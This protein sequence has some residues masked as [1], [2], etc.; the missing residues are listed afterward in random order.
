MGIFYMLFEIRD[1]EKKKAKIPHDL[2]LVNLMGNHILMFV[3]ALG[4]AARWVWPLS[5]IT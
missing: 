4:L 2:F 5:F 3:S 1:E